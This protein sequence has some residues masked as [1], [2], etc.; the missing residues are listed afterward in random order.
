MYT[1]IC[2]NGGTGNCTGTPILTTDGTN[3]TATCCVCGL[4]YASDP[5]RDTAV[6]NWNQQ[7]S[8]PPQAAPTTP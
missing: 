7:V 3:W 8:P 1:R 2:G 6:A 4:A 5:S